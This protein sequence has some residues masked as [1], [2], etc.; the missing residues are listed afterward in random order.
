MPEEGS[1]HLAEESF[2]DVEPGAVLGCEY[3]LESVRI[4]CQKGSRF[5]GDV[6]GMV[7]QDDPDR[8]IRRV[9]GI[10]VR[11]ESFEFYAA[12][13]AFDPCSDVAVMK[14]QSRQ[15]RTGAQA[16]VFMI[17]ADFR[18]PARHRWQVRRCIRDG[19]QTGFLVNRDGDQAGWAFTDGG[20][21]LILQ[22]DLLVHDQDFAHLRFEIRVASLQ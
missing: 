13:T 20:M 12:M 9:P 7:V 1:C 4:Y 22:S 8:A 11:Q 14:I 6:L 18:M 17:A 10:E 15:N 3:V 5:F 2:N 19:L 16:F 21:S